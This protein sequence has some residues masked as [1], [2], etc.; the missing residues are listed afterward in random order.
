[1]DLAMLNSRQASL[2]NSIS[3]YSAKL[4]K[5]REKKRRLLEAQKQFAEDVT[6][7]EATNKLFQA[8]EVQEDGWKGERA[9]AFKTIYEQK[10]LSNLKKFIG[11]LGEVDVAIS[12]AIQRIESEIAACEASISVAQSS[13][14]VV[15][16]DIKSAQLEKG[17]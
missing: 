10:V 5:L 14:A 7:I 9:T 13:L 17:N 6:G 3:H 2:S 1:M 11:Q 15:K 8:L 16:A 12:E 4:A